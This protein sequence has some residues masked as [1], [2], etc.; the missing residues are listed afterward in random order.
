MRVFVPSAGWLLAAVQPE[1]R[2]QGHTA[3]GKPLEASRRL[4]SWAGA[5]TDGLSADVSLV[6]PRCNIVSAQ[7]AGSGIIVPVM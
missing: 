2:S 5:L 4:I 3:P 6:P 1:A 7:N